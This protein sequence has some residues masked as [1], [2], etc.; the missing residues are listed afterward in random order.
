MP[1]YDGMVVRWQFSLIGYGGDLGG[2]SS[3]AA[4]SRSF[5]DRTELYTVLAAVRADE[6]L[7]G[8]CQGAPGL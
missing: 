2:S 8:G 1:T 7:M 4:G 3:T 6:G 5:M